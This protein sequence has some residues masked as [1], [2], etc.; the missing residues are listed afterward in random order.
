MGSSWVREFW[1]GWFYVVN[2][3]SVVWM[4]GVRREGFGDA[5]FLLRRVIWEV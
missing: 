2:W 1:F 4:Q 3:G 5:R